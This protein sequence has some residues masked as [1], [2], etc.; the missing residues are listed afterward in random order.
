[1]P[2]SDL[3]KKSPRKEPAGDDPFGS[4][5]LQKKRHDAALEFLNILQRNFLSPDGKGHA[6]TVLS[7]AAW[8]AGTS[9]YRSLNYKGD[10][11]PG[12]VMLSNE[13]NKVWP[14]LMNLFMYYCQRNGIALQPD[15]L[16]L[17]IPDEHKPQIEIRQIQEKLQDQYNAIMKKHDLDYLDGARAG[18]I[19]C[20]IIFHYHCTRAR[21]IDPEVAAGIVSMGILEG[22]KTAPPPLKPES[23]STSASQNNQPA[24]LLKSIAQNSTDGS[25]AR[26]VLGEGMTPMQEALHNGGRYILVHPEVS[27]QLKQN[28]IDPFLVYEAALYTEIASSIPRIDFAGV[29]VDELLQSWSGKPEEQAPIHVRQALWLQRNANQFGYEK[30]G[31][32]WTLKP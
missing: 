31:N 21:D 2:L 20:S 7:A 32:S 18:V 19:I 22:A 4:S 10:P 3:F 27:N 30:S 25:G 12:T 5:E 17:Q 29:N 24:D 14:Q 26:L 9:L 16:V 15:Q 8:L 11:A 13:V 28:N 6:G 1:M 23:S